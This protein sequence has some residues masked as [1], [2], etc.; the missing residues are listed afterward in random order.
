[1]LDGD[2]CVGSAELASRVC[3]L[4]VT[5]EPIDGR[6]SLACTLLRPLMAF[7]ETSRIIRAALSQSQPASARELLGEQVVSLLG[8]IH[9]LFFVEMNGA[10]AMLALASRAAKEVMQAKERWEL[11]TAYVAMLCDVLMHP[12]GVCAIPDTVVHAL[13]FG[14][15]DDEHRTG[16]PAPLQASL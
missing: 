10:G 15:R 8:A 3:G 5:N 4:A 12:D 6:Q 14:D 2:C 16:V 9:T 7:S 13:C 11:R 1:M